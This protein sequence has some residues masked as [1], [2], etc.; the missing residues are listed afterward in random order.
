MEEPAA[1]YRIGVDVGGTFT[2]IVLISP[3]GRAVPK[4]VLSSPPRFNVAIRQGVAEALAEN[5]VA[6]SAVR[7][8]PHGA[9]VATNA[10]ITRTGAAT[11]LVTTE[12]FRDV[13]EIRRMRMHKL[14]DIHWEW[15]C[16]RAAAASR[17]STRRGR[18]RWGRRAPERCRAPPAT[19]RAGWSRRSRMRTST[20]ASP[21]ARRARAGR[22]GSAP[23]S[24][25]A[26]LDDWSNIVLEREGT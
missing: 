4:K 20:S 15:S 18:S 26:R 2:D 8:F 24:R 12:G 25:S 7:S 22:S 3:E 17:G 11:G 5:G 19:T 14:Y 13:L 16:S 1:R 6:A 23:T 9:T 21:T 10:I